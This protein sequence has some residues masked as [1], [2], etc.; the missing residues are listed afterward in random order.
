MKI[1]LENLGKFNEGERIGGWL[2]LPY[3]EEELED[4][5]IEIKVANKEGGN[6]SFGY[7]HENKLYEEYAIHD[8]ESEYGFDI[9][10]SE[11]EQVSRLNDISLD[12]ERLTTDEIEVLNAFLVLYGNN[13]ENLEIG[14]KV[15]QDNR[16]VIY[17]DCRDAKDLGYTYMLITN[18]LED[19]SSEV[20][21][22]LNFEKVAND[23]MV[24]GTFIQLEDKYIEFIH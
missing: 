18:Q 11:Y 5:L 2:K 1:L 16:Y 13:I 9:Y 24:G 17:S 20:K 10:I 19:L 21:K 4:L 23:L 8:F 12:L 14:I 3:K 22:Y 7:V 15:I 6:F